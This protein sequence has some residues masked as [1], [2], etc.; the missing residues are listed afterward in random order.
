MEAR[1]FSDF[2]RLFKKNLWQSIPWSEFQKSLGK[3]VYFLG[4]DEA[5][6]LLVVQRLPFGLCYLDLPRGPLGSPDNAF[7][8]DLKKIAKK[9][10]AVFA[11]LSPED[12]LNSKPVFSFRSSAKHFPERTIKIDLRLSEDEILKQMK[13]KGR[14]NIRLAQRHKV[15]VFKTD[16]VEDF[17]ELL[18]ETGDRDGFSH[19]PISYYETM[20]SVL[21]DSARLYLAKAEIN[22][23]MRVIAG[24]IFS[25]LEEDCIYYYGASAR[26]KNARDKMAPYLIQWQAIL[27]A[28]KEGKQSLDL[29]GIATD[30]SPRHSLAG[31]TRFKKQFGGQII[32]YP[33]AIEIVY[34]PFMYFAYRLWQFLKNLF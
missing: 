7:Y 23:E 24:G 29:L 1:N 14:Y 3:S 12:R 13:P 25:F 8:D 33:P 10:R 21:G 4:D 20:L 30:D 2:R 34:R 5:S 27:D 32:N 6:S 11:R 31:V 16:S 17:Y 15:E 18:K 9:E 28:K 26:D 22:D 19:H